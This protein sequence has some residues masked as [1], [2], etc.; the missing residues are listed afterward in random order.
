VRACVL[1]CEG[2]CIRAL[3]HPC[4][5]ACV[6]HGSEGGWCSQGRIGPDTLLQPLLLLPTAKRQAGCACGCGAA[7]VAAAVAAGC[8]GAGLAELVRLGLPAHGKGGC[9]LLPLLTACK[10]P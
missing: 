7:A 6:P 1:M 10:L 5:H 2:A 4:V 3:V 9:V 8:A